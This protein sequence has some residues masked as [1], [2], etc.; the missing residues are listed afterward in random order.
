[1]TCRNKNA[2][3]DRLIASSINDMYGINFTFIGKCVEFSKY[4]DSKRNLVMYKSNCNYCS[5]HIV[6]KMQ[7][8]I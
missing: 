6:R 7:F 1:M 3:F 4:R 2:F 8:T 5:R